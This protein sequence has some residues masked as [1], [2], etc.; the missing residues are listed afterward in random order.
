MKN[1]SRTPDVLASTEIRELVFFWKTSKLVCEVGPAAAQLDGH[2][3][4]QRE[5]EQHKNEI[6]LDKKHKKETKS[7]TMKAKERKIV[8]HTIIGPADKTEA[9]VLS[10]IDIAVVGGG[11]SVY[12]QPDEDPT[13]E[14]VVTPSSNTRS[15]FHANTSQCCLLSFP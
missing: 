10:E 7:F 5:A 12:P 14:T 11:L 1:R 3:S 13:E 4:R 9:P 8:L 15:L 6:V 2:G